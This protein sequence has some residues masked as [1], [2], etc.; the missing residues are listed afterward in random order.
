MKSIKRII[1]KVIF[2]FNVLIHFRNEPFFNLKLLF[3]NL[4]KDQLYLTSKSQIQYQNNLRIRTSEE[5]YWLEINDVEVLYPK[6]FSQGKAFENFKSVIEEQ[7]PGHPH[8]YNYEMIQ[9]GWIIYD[10]GTAEGYQVFQWFK[11][12]K[13]VILFEPDPDFYNCLRITFSN[14]IETGK[15]MLINYGI[16]E[17]EEA[18][19]NG[20]LKFA[21]LPDLIEKFS[22][23]SPDYIKADIEGNELF[24]L[25]SMKSLLEAR[26]IKMIEITTYHR[27][28]DY[29]EIKEYLTRF[30]GESFYSNGNILLNI[31]GW[32]NIGSFLRLYQPV[33]RKVLYTHKF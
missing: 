13:K 33:I 6:S 9:P 32:E 30:G 24:L 3:D 29:R 19:G 10:I 28:N 14:E 18:F 31:N 8:K 4:F 7:S 11:K 25:H 5:G 2:F 1:K 17:C 15:I 12:A 16:G 20:S 22:L 27:P 26:T 21:H 23:P